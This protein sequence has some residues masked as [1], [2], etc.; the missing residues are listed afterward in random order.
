MRLILLAV[1]LA[2]FISETYASTDSLIIKG[3]ILN[4][5]GRLYRHAP[6]ITFSRNNILQPQSELS[7]QAPLEADGSFRLSLPILFPNE[8]FYLDYGGRA[9]TTFL[10]SKGTVE[11]TFDADSLGRAKKLFYFAGVNA[12]ANNQ[13]M[14]YVAAENQLLTSNKSLGTDFF[15]FFWETSAT[16]AKALA[17]KRA[18]LRLSAIQNVS[19]NRVYSPTLYNW[20][21]SI[22]D[23]EQLQILFEHALSN[24]TDL[25]KDLLD[26][27]NRLA[28]PPLTAQRVL[29]ANRFGAYADQRVNERKYANPTRTNSL[30]VRLMATLI[31]NNVTTLTSEEKQRL[32]DIQANGIA[33]KGELDFLN[34]IF[35]KNEMVLNLL[36]NFERESRIYSDLF[37]STATEFL[38]ARYLAKNL[39][40]FTYKQQ[41]LLNSH[42]QSRIGLPQFRQSVDEIVRLEVKDS[43]DIRKIV[44][45][46]DLKTDPTEV[47]PGYFI[48][49]SRDRGTSWLNRLLDLYKGKTIYLSKWNLDDTKSREELDYMPMLQAQVPQNVVFVYLHLAG[50]ELVVSD[51]LLKQYIVRHKLKGVHLFLDSRQSMDLLFKLNPLDAAT[52]ALIRPNGK[53]ALKNAPSPSNTEKTATAIIEANKP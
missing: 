43:S 27:L 9:F 53:F 24:Q 19:Q 41:L 5:N 7:K 8:E 37:D 33:E 1:F 49:A 30:P 4:L 25:G 34:K 15:R 12:D 23:E 6:S 44:E 11:I 28:A 52:F 45:F 20:A 48:A 17:A 50:E 46:K 22:A 47:L 51:A 38:K 2:G 18:Q 42:I 35:A 21:K 14:Q 16:E 36:F 32:A 29:W 10:G 26:S 39:F 3:R 13:F 31:K 40:R